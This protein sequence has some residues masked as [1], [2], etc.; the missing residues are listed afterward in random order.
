VG[1][2]DRAFVGALGIVFGLI[3]FGVLAIGPGPRLGT[4]WFWFWLLLL[5]PYGLGVIFWMLRDRPWAP[6][7]QAPPRRDRGVFGLVTGLLVAF[8]IGAGLGVFD[9]SL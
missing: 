1:R 8:L 5:A 9:I 7:A 6:V 3:S 4:R 2:R